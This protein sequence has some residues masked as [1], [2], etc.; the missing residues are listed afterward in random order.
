MKKAWALLALLAASV[1]PAAAQSNQVIDRLLEQPRASFGASAYLVLAASGL[2]DAEASEQ[3]AL[4]A[5]GEKGWKLTARG[6]DEPIRLGEYC[7]LIMEAFEVKGGLMYRI[8]PGPR[9][10]VRELAYLEIVHGKAHGARLPSGQEAVQVLSSFLNR[11]GGG[12]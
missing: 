12:E 4:A 2:I 11:K 6:A 1:L 9:Y 8:F 7:Y 3:Q 10:A 5:L